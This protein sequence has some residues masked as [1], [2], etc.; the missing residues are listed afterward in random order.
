MEA[1]VRSDV[2]RL[3]TAWGGGDQ[4]AFDQ[5]GPVIYDELRRLARGQMRR[6]RQRGTLQ[7]TALVHEAFLR[8]TGQNQVAWESRGHFYAIAARMMRR[9]LVDFARRRSG[10]KRGGDVPRIPLD[11]APE[12]TSQPADDV[13]AVHDALES[14]SAV[15]GRKAQMVELRFFGGLSIDE[16]AE[17][18]GVSP[19][20]V[21][22]DWTLAK[23]WL[24]REIRGESPSSTGLATPGDPVPTGRG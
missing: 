6:E 13:L 8:L 3:L 14:L 5:L 23:A 15:D 18:L 11:E 7:T 17:I 2:T 21:M 4:E 12:I 24:Q 9:V 19:G 16:T 1:S 20:T 10:K 22:R